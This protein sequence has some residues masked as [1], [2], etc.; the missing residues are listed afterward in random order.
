MNFGTYYLFFYYKVLPLI[1]WCYDYFSFCLH[2]FFMNYLNHFSS[3]YENNSIVLNYW[4]IKIFWINFFKKNLLLDFLYKNVAYL[5]IYYIL[6]LSVLFFSEKYI[7]EYQTKYIFN[8]IHLLFYIQWK[9]YF[10]NWNVFIQPS[11]FMILIY[12]NFIFYFF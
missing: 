8:F 9:N 2:Y 3:N 10:L 11:I 6:N 4:F 7:I 1:L 5:Y 12:L